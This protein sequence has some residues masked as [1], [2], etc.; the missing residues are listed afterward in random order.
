[1]RVAHE[2]ALQ[3][4]QVSSSGVRGVWQRHNLLT[5]HDRRR[6]LERATAERDLTL[7]DEQRHLLERFSP[8]F[9]ER[10][11]EAPHSG[12]LVAV[13]TF[14]VGVLKGVGKV[15][16]QT[17]IDCASRYAW[18]RLYPNKL[19][20]TAL[21]LLNNDVLPTFEQHG[22]SIEAVLSDNGREFCGRDERH[23]YELFLQLEGIAHK[24]T[25]V[26]G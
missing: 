19:P 1:M 8:E 7:S 10:H 4:V 25:R 15:Y 11:I 20:V 18:A 24:R 26:R 22:A 13:D 12:A 5:K 2:L 23:P 9:R 6:R 17:A 16:L 14:F 21:Q 3:G